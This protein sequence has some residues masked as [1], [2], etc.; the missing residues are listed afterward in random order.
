MASPND[1]ASQPRR[2][3]EAISAAAA[4]FLPWPVPAAFGRGGLRLG[5][6]VG[7][8]LSIDL[9]WFMVLA[10]GAGV[11]TGHLGGFAAAGSVAAWAC[12]SDGADRRVEPPW[13]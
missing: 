10:G 8:S 12:A 7:S 9:A 2:L 3:C 5:V 4:F 11:L 1:C 13:V 6:R